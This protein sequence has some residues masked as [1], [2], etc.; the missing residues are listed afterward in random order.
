MHALDLHTIEKS[1]Q[2]YVF[3]NAVSLQRTRDGV[4]SF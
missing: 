4:D 1:N 2:I 3:L